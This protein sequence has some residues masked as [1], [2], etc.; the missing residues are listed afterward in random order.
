MTGRLPPLRA[1]GCF[2]TAARLGSFTIAA[3]ELCLTPSAVSR[4][5]RL[6]EEH[7]GFLLFHRVGRKMVLTDAG[8]AYHDFVSQPLKRIGDAKAHLKNRQRR[9]TLYV[10]MPSDFASAW[11]M[12]RLSGFAARYPDVEVNIVTRDR[13]AWSADQ[14]GL[15]AEIRYGHGKW[16]T[17]TAIPLIRDCLLPVCSPAL[18]EAGPMRQPADVVRHRLIYTTSR[19]VDWRAWSDHFGVAIDNAA[20]VRI[21]RSSLVREAAMSG[22]GIALESRLCAEQSIALGRLVAPLPEAGYEEGSYYYVVG[23]S[24]EETEKAKAFRT[25]LIEEF[26]TYQQEQADR[27]SRTATM[28]DIRSA[29]RILA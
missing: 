8:R 9:D 22:V 18:A 28:T 20:S 25:W 2:E 27:R 26:A 17:Y 3:D 23:R 15:D 16:P 4:Q 29:R 24:S 10:K 21:D 14:D 13:D 6:L 19:S 5:I 7:L 11:F 1:L 12:S